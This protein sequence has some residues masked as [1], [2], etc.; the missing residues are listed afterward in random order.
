MSQIMRI[1]LCT[2][3]LWT[4]ALAGFN[5]NGQQ[6][7]VRTVTAKTDGKLKLNV[8]LGFNYAL[9]KQFVQGPDNNPGFV[10]TPGP[11]VESG[12]NPAQAISGNL[13]AALGLTSFWDLAI[14]LP[15]YADVVGVENL[16]AWGIGDMDISM[17]LLYP[18]PSSPRVFYQSYLLGVTAPTGAGFLNEGYFPRE[19]YY[20]A[21]NSDDDEP[22]HYYASDTPNL[23]SLLLWTLDFKNLERS[24]PLRIHVNVGAGF[25]LDRDRE[26][27]AI[28]G[29]AL[30]YM[31]SPVVSIFVDGW[32]ESRWRTL[33]TGFTLTRDPLYVTPGVRINA[34]SG[35]SLM[36]AGDFCLSSILDELR[37]EHT[38]DGY[39]YSIETRPRWGA[40]FAFSWSGF[41]TPQDDDHDG[42]KNDADR[43]PKDAEDIDEYEDSDG[44]P[45]TDNDSDG[46]PDLKDKCPNAAED[47]DGFED[48]DG[49]PD[50]DNDG[51]GILDVDDQCPKIAEDFDGIEDK[52][53]CPDGDNDKDGIP[54]TLD[55]CPNDPEDIDK[56]ED[57]D[58]CPDI[59][60]DKD[61][62][63]DLKDKCPNEPETINGVDDDDGCPD[64]KKKDAPM[65]K[66]QILKGVKFPSGS[67]EMTFES[68]QYLDPIIKIMKEYPNVE[69]EIRG[70]TDSIGKYESNMRL[71]Q[72]RA[73][74]VRRYL[75][76]QG[77]DPTRMR[78]V[79]FGPSSPIADNRTAAG[80]AANRRIEIVRI[81]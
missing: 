21:A 48:E 58:G 23:R 67:V 63:Q 10:A 45:D 61:G 7:V 25:S 46:I 35:V 68:H 72:K 13:Y 81:K 59:D 78:A 12:A 17:K 32:G 74:S 36:F 52:N 5:S 26:N 75:I 76:S 1:V 38:R 29:L 62:I 15:V 14:A 8:G 40:Q 11:M 53:G 54:D 57:D 16:S 73:D 9:D 34:P 39:T 3:I 64:E 2:A 69:I 24:V 4:C 66:H 55:K 71:S 19:Q 70:H 50:P 49:C 65:P 51:D 80:R 42:V 77:I 43:C 79:G 56:Y 44:C 41:L 22:L 6:G 18:P 60:N 33:E 30:E 37:T 47:T 20:Y 31:P 27:T 28:G